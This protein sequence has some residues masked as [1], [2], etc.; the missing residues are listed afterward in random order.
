MKEK[1]EKKIITKIFQKKEKIKYENK[2]NHNL[3]DTLCCGKQ[4]TNYN[5]FE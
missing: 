2:V 5:E 1:N 4:R 3:R